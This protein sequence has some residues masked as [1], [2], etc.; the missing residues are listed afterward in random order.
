[1]DSLSAFLRSGKR[2]VRSANLDQALA[3]TTVWQV[4]NL[5]GNEG[6]RVLG[7]SSAYHA[8]KARL[9]LSLHPEGSPAAKAE[10]FSS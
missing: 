3:W 9:P 8:I 7:A 6:V 4:L 5:H 1:M 2:A 10:R